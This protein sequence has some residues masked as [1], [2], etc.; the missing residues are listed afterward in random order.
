[1]ILLDTNICIYV[2]KGRP[3]AVLERFNAH[4]PGELAVSVITAM[5]LRV[6][7]RKAGLDS[8]P[9]RRVAALLQRLQVLPLGAEAIDH[10]ASLR[11]ALEGQGALIGPMDLLI[12]AH[13]LALGAT[14]V[15]HNTR[16]FQRVP[17]LAF[18]DWASA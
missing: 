4:E 12:A 16:E 6:G 1:M 9:A 17:G 8:R 18:E 10:Y 11:L 2:V 15:T 5:E 13:A 14:L 3:A 7:A